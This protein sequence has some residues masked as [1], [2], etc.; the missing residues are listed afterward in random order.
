M[1]DTKFDYRRSSNR[2]FQ[3]HGPYKD[4]DQ[5]LPITHEYESYFDLLFSIYARPI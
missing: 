3:M 2:A 1:L 5:W 4:R